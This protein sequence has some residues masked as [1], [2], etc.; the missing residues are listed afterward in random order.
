MEF[1]DKLKTLREKNGWTQE[2]LGEKLFVSR[3]TVSKWET[4]RGLPNLDSLLRLSEICGI[5]INDL[6]STDKAIE[7]GRNEVKAEKDREKFR[8]LSI[9]DILTFLLLILPLFRNVQEGT[10]TSVPLI[11][12]PMTNP[13]LKGILV[14]LIALGIGL[15]LI[16]ILKNKS[17][18]K[19]SLGVSGLLAAI[20]ILALQPY[21]ALFVLFLIVAKVSI[22]MLR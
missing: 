16:A 3:V 10:M 6:I 4:G 12:T 13:W 15:G 18:W 20:L 1:G 2:E 5:S 17:L 19:V 22:L 7:C 21:P 9:L 8:F 11:L 14:F